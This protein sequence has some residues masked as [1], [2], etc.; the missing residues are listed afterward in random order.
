MAAVNSP[1]TCPATIEARSKR[2]PLIFS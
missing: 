2:C 1:S